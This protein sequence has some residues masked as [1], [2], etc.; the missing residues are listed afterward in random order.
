M[1]KIELE[2]ED[3]IGIILAI[4][5]AG[6]LIFALIDKK[7]SEIQKSEIQCT[8]NKLYTEKRFDASVKHTVTYYWLVADTEDKSQQIQFQINKGSYESTAANEDIVVYKYERSGAYTGANY[9]QYEFKGQDITK[10]ITFSALSVEE[11]T[12]K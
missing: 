9:D 4:V 12:A 6:F 5:I 7:G 1:R 2:T 8:V 11:K 3:I 10:S